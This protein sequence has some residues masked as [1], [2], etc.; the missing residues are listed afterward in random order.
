MR[1]IRDW[2]S[3]LIDA[4]TLQRVLALPL[5]VTFVTL[6]VRYGP[7]LAQ[8]ANRPVLLAA[9]PWAFGAIA[10]LTLLLLFVVTYATRLRLSLL[11][12]M[13]LVCDPEQGS[14]VRTRVAKFALKDGQPVHAED[15]QPVGTEVMASSIRISVRAT[16]R[17]APKNATAFLT[18]FEKL[19]EAGE[20]ESS[21]YNELVQLPW[22]GETMTADL[23][24]LFPR[25]V[26]VFHIEDD[27][28]IGFWMVG[29]PFSLVDFFQPVTRYRLTVAVIADG[30]T[31]QT[32]FELDWT[33]KWDTVT[34]RPAPTPSCPAPFARGHAKRRLLRLVAMLTPGIRR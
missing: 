4:F 20:W 21:R 29:M 17:V 34:L 8:E 33:G 12:K 28:K 26:S 5:F 30:T 6:A 24:D 7:I 10:G 14:L 18:K 2:L 1:G 27:N 9:P 23:S 13:V 32:T 15:G 11:P 16:T 3:T 25:F 22:V 19:N 31:Q